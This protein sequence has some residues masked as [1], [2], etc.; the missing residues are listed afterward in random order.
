MSAEHSRHR[1]SARLEQTR[2]LMRVRP[3]SMRAE[4]GYLR[5]IEEFLS[6][7]RWNA[8]TATNSI[9]MR[10]ERSSNSI[11]VVF[12]LFVVTS[13]PRVAG[14]NPACA[15][16]SGWRGLLEARSLPGDWPEKEVRNGAKVHRN[17]GGSA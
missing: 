4:E 10:V 13:F 2:Q 6:G 3:L 16:M 15:G 11:F 8:V 12:A 5:W 1:K 9:I 17:G 14:W 7:C